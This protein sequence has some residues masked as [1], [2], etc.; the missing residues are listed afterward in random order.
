MTEHQTTRSI[1][2]TSDRDRATARHRHDHAA[3]RATFSWERERAALCEPHHVNI[4]DIAID[5]HVRQGRGDDTALRWRG[6]DGA[7]LDLTFAELKTSGDRFAGL[8][9]RLGIG[10]CDVVAVMMPRRPELFA[11]AFGAWK[12]RSVFCP[13][14]VAFGPEPVR[15][16]LERAGARVLITTTTLYRRKVAGMRD[17]LP[18]L[19]Y[20][21]L[22]DTSL[23]EEMP[24]GTLDYQGQLALAKEPIALPSTAPDDLAILHFTSGTTGPPKG[25]LHVHDAVIAHHATARLCSISD[26]G[27][28]IG[29]PPI[30]AG[31]PAPP[32]ASSR[33]SRSAP[34]SSW[35]RR[36]SSRRG[37]I[38]C[39]RKS[40]LRSGTPRRRRSAC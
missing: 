5:R 19:D 30:P 4:A 8:L 15:A 18:S 16:R 9:Q 35:T 36:S 11:A 32:T 40:G 33:R 34:R 20:V 22:I 27:T 38:G 37:G 25:A 7:R 21:L 3:A 2:A 28:S 6:R 31:S 23:S 1:I 39:S 12:N 26:P 13:L 24:D 10:P 14:F 29:A 17:R